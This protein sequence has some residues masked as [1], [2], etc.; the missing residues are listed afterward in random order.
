VRPDV[1]PGRLA[2]ARSQL[3]HV[4]A[5]LRAA[6]A[7]RGAILAMLCL[8]A[9]TLVPAG[10]AEVGTQLAHLHCVLAGAAHELRGEPA[11]RSALIVQ[12]DTAGHHLGGRLLQ[13][14]RSAGVAGLGAFVASLNARLELILHHDLLLERG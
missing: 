12:C 13:A 7:C 10:F 14:G 1:L 6:A 3:A 9:G 5:L 4:A 8:V 11:D 2:G